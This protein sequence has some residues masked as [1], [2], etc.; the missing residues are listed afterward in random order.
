MHSRQENCC[1]LSYFKYAKT[2]VTTNFVMVLVAK[3]QMQ[4]HACACAEPQRSAIFKLTKSTLYLLDGCYEIKGAFYVTLF[5]TNVSANHP[6]LCSSKS[7][8]DI[9]YKT[10]HIL[11][12]WVTMEWDYPL[13]R[14]SSLVSW[15]VLP[16]R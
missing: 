9:E 2:S 16:S 4:G 14:S 15:W 12:T 10:Q 3:P 1:Y 6:L 11:G 13:H 5:M 8:L 7:I